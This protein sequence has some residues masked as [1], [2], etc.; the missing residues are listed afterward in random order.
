MNDPSLITVRRAITDDIASLSAVSQVDYDGI[1]LKLNQ[2]SNQVDNLQ[3]ADNDSDG[4]P[5]DSDG[6][7]LSS[8]ISEWRINL[9]KSWQNFMDNFITIRRRDDTALVAASAKSGY[10]SA[11]VFALA[12]WSQHK[13]YRVTSKRLIARRWRTSP[14]GYVL[15]TI[16][17]MPPPKRS[18]DEVDQ[19]SQQNIELIFRKPCKARRCWKN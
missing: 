12:C 14:P 5:M 19:L 4:S 1:I 3:L 9:Q 10:L 2:L 15:T 18:L 16:L 17:M 6:E 7:E 11:R 13:L 8:S